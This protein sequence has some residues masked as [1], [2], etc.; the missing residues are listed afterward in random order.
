M[1]IAAS[2]VRL[3]VSE[4]S[5]EVPSRPPSFHEKAMSTKVADVAATTVIERVVSPIAPA[6]IRTLFSAVAGSMIRSGASVA[7]ISQS[8]SSGE[9]ARSASQSTG[10][11]VKA[12]KAQGHVVTLSGTFVVQLCSGLWY[13]FLT[14]KPDCYSG[15]YTG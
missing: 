3:D 10:R 14:G 8:E 1:E 6:S 12:Y 5:T 15:G 7:A 4:R 11:G 2:G 13:T 9:A